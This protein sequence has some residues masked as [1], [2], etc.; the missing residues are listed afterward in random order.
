MSIL[1]T[2]LLA[3]AI[4]SAAPDPIEAD[5]AWVAEGEFCEPETVLALPDDTLLVS[6]VCDFRQRGNGFLSLLDAQGRALDWRVLEG[7]DAPLGM[8]MAAGRLYLIDNNQVKIFTW[9]DYALLKTIGL[10][11]TVANDLAV[12]ETGVIYVTD[13]ARH[14]VMRV[15]P[16]G[17]QS[18]LTGQARFKNANG[19]AVHEGRLYVGGERLWRVDLD[20]DSVEN[21]GPDWISDIDGIEFEPDGTLQLTPVAGPLIRFN[22]KNEVE[23]FAGQG[24]SSANHGYAANLQLALIPTGFDNT[25]I[26][27]RVAQRMQPEHNR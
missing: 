9:P 19:I 12:S 2:L 26:A 8:A 16:D 13:T 21:F 22:G 5:I 10:E 1:T 23:V 14:Q 15:L 7:L 6:N 11:T 4:T 18:V 25:V 20:D 27:I 3:A 24:I 17:A